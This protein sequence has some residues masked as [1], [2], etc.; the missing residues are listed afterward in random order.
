MTTVIGSEATITLADGSERVVAVPAMLKIEI[1]MAVTIFDRG[2][3][4]LAYK[5]GD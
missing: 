1:G 4:Q 2:D 3:G 5:W